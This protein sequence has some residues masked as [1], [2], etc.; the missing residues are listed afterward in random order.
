MTKHDDRRCCGLIGLALLGAGALG[1]SELNTPLYFKG[2][3][4]VAVGNEDTL[5]MGSV[6]LRFRAPT[7]QEQKQLDAERD[8][9]GYDMDIPWVSRDKVHVEVSYKVTYRCPTPD[10]M[11]DFDQGMCKDLPPT[12]TFTLMVDGAS[13]YTKYDTQMVSAALQQGPNDPPTFLPLIPTV[14]Q[15]LAPGQS[16][17]GVVREDDFAEGEV[18]MDALGRWNDPNPASPTFAGVLINRSEVSP[19]IGMGMVP[20]FSINQVG[21]A[22][23]NPNVLVVPAMI[24]VDLRLKS[25]VPMAVEYF[26][27]VRDDDDRLWHNDSDPRFDFTPTLFQPPAMM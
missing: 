6:T 13:Q 12:G 26:V 21:Q 16:Y 17:S 8:A 20:G 18:D 1:C 19:H 15:M 10:E 2:D 22:E 7:D 14:P 3:T 9:K 25:D 27:R 23:F 4:F 5:P 11:P 24:E